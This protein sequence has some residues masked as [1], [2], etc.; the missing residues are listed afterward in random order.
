MKIYNVGWYEKQNFGDEEMRNQFSS[1][2]HSIGFDYKSYSSHG[3]KGAKKIDPFDADVIVVGGG[4]ILNKN[5]WLFKNYPLEEFSRPKKYIFMNV[6]IGSIETFPEQ[7]VNTIVENSSV[8]W[9]VRDSYSQ[10]FL[11]DKGYKNVYMV[12]DIVFDGFGANGW[13]NLKEPKQMGVICNHFL[14][15]GLFSKDSTERNKIQHYFNQIAEYLD[16]MQSFGWNINF[17]PL[18]TAD[19]ADDRIYNSYLYGLNG[20]RG[21]NHTEGIGFY[22]EEIKKYLAKCSLIISSRY[23]GT[24]CALAN[25][26]PVID[27]TFDAKTRNL[28]E[29]IGQAETSLCVEDISKKALVERTISVEKQAEYNWIKKYAVEQWDL[30]KVIIKEFINE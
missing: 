26:T 15:K 7:I 9:I 11:M 6:G 14:F 12:P 18:Q 13:Q 21:K 22:N 1:F 24:V 5:F 30:M 17:I 10:D 16:W 25:S 3:E 4:N 20:F 2:F 8:L 27:L 19:Q 23:H 29:D 28:L